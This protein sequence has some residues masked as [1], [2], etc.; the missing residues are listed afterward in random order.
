M[1]SDQAVIEGPGWVRT[2]YLLVGKKS[3]LGF[4][5]VAPKKTATAPYCYTYRP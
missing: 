1:R 3:V 4:R 2:D 5:G